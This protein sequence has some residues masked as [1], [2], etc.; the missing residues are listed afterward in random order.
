MEA[1]T[2]YSSQPRIGDFVAILR[3][4]LGLIGITVGIVFALAI[5]YLLVATPYYTASTQILVDPRK[6]NTVKNEVVPSGLGTTASDNFA[7]VDSQVKVIMSSTVLRPVV[8][9][10]HLAADPEFN[11]E[12]PSVL[13]SLMGFLSD[14][15]SSPSNVAFSPEDHALLTL[16]DQIK[17]TRDPQTYVIKIDVTTSDP[18]KS[19]HIAQAIATSY[20]DDQ[21]QSKIDTTQQASTQIYGQ[22][23]TLRQ[24]LLEAESN[25]QKFRA[26]NN[27]QQSEN[28][29]LIDTRQ[30]EQ[31]N[32]TLTDAQAEVAQTEAK[33]EQVQRLLRDGIDPDMVADAIKSE[34]VSRLRDQYA[35][36]SRKEAILGTTLLPSHP[37]IKQAHS[38]VERLAGLIRAEI[39]RI[40]A[41]VKLDNEAAH[42]RLKAA[43]AAVEASRQE[44]NSHDS[45]YIKLRELEREAETTRT[46]YESFLS[47][48]KEMNETEQVDTPDARIISPATIPSRPSWPKKLLILA[49]ALVFGSVLGGSLAFATE[50]LDRRIYSETELLT[51]T[52]LKPL[53]SIPRLHAKA[54]LV[55]RLLHSR[56]PNFYDLVVETLEGDQRSGFRASVFR[57]LSYLVDFNTGDQP[58]VV[59]LTSS[60]RGEGKSALALSLAV[61]AASSGI[62]T[63]LV[64]ASTAHPGLTQVLGKGND[65]AELR[66]RM[67]TDQRLGLSFLSLV[68]DNQSL[69]GWPSRTDLT[70]ELRQI[71]ADY[72]LTLIDAGLLSGERNVACL[73]A[74][75]QAILFLSRASVTSQQVAASAAADL[76]QMANGRRCA[77][78]LTMASAEQF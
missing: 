45:A 54:G 42:Q 71:T 49:L 30:L 51:S 23:A 12:A 76:L 3:R 70:D 73:M 39:E 14:V 24:R 74:I 28:G 4:R 63:L 72:D 29:V 8:K 13:G 15:F 2:V 66:H 69:T 61:A 46:V 68:G 52:G 7:L 25:V 47:R 67:V 36:A 32:K 27:L 53:V 1:V 38:E 9:S 5:G 16:Q 17:V 20:L 62:R 35:I 18:I 50:H 6:K 19:A 60:L 11:G 48:V 31:L 10:Q 65:A 26:D 64:D 57:L 77:A 55:E 41:A 22:I 44:A 43:E 56:K 40:T 58:R 34:T 78:V 59:L 75:S 37:M 21:S 33:N